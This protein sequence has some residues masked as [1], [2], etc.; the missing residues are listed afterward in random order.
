MA[1]EQGDIFWVTLTGSGS[2]QQG[3][4][5][6]IVMSRTAINNAGKT[7]VI[8]PMTTTKNSTDPRFRIVLPTTEILK[9]PSCNS[10]LCDSIAK[11]DHVRVLDKSLLERKRLT[12][13]S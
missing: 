4:R 13:P 3:R 2:E 6:C 1:I 9:D 11:C 10:A 12:K 7:V 5:P 8:V